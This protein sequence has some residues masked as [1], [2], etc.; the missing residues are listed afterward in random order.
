MRNMQT[1]KGSG[2]GI[3][4]LMIAASFLLLL[5]GCQGPMGPQGARTGTVSLTIGQ[6]DMSRALQ[7]DIG[8]ED[9]DDFSIVFSR[10]GTTLPP[11]DWDDDN[12]VITAQ[13]E[14]AE[15]TWNLKVEA[16][17]D[18]YVVAYFDEPVNVVAPFTGLDIY[19]RPYRESGY[20][21]FA[22][23]LTLPDAEYVEIAEGIV[24][25]FFGTVLVAYDDTLSAGDIYDGEWAGKFDDL[26]AGDYFVVVTLTTQAGVSVSISTY[27]HV[28]RNLTTTLEHEFLVADFP[29][30]AEVALARIN[31]A[32]W[33]PFTQP[34]EEGVSEEDTVA[35]ALNRVRG[36]VND[37]V[38]AA[39]VDAIA[40]V[41]WVTVP[42]LEELGT[43][44]TSY[45]FTV[46]VEGGDGSLE[47]TVINV[48][49]TFGAYGVVVTVELEDAIDEAMYLLGNTYISDDGLD[50]EISDYWAPPLA[51]EALGDA[52]D[53]AETYLG[54]TQTQV[55]EAVIA[56]NEAIDDFL[57]ARERG[58][59]DPFLTAARGLLAGV[60]EEAEELL[61]Y[62]E[63]A[64]HTV[65]TW[66]AFTTAL[67][68]AQ[69]AYAN[70]VTVPALN[71]AREALEE[72]MNGLETLLEE[73]L[74]LLAAAIANAPAIQGDYSDD[75]WEAFETALS[76][77][78][79]AYA[80]AVTVLDLD[81]ARVALAAAIGGLET[82]IQETRKLLGLALDLANPRLSDHYTVDSWSGFPGIRLAA[83]EAYANDAAT[84]EQL[85]AA[86]TAL[87]TAMGNLIPRTEYYRELLAEALG[88]AD[89]RVQ[90]TYTGDSWNAFVVIRE[91]SRDVHDDDDA[92]V[93]ALS[94]ANTN[95]RNA[96]ANVLVTA[97]DQAAVNAAV[98]TVRAALAPLASNE[99]TAAELLAAANAA[100]TGG[101][102]AAWEVDFGRTNATQADV[103]EITGTIRLRLGNAIADVVLD[104]EIPALPVPGTVVIN[105][106]GFANPLLAEGLT[107]TATGAL[108]GPGTFAITG[109]SEALGALEN[110]RWYEGTNRIGTGLM[111]DRNWM[112]PVVTVWVDVG[113]STYSRIVVLTS[114][115]N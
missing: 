69:Y 51:H 102:T 108:G 82:V 83:Q 56:L 89:L 50:V 79:Y 96:M 4:A 98:A 109:S 6:L 42:D 60:I 34:W 23:L 35:I 53:L 43:P 55:N 84:L 54:G 73:A 31:A 38:Y 75:S 40:T 8:L 25:V 72:A 49:I 85:Q 100:L 26:T 64:D 113:D 15:G 10:D 28:Y 111:L 78:Q 21:V 7:P 12:G 97:V 66:E 87:N 1:L 39:G 114:A 81:T 62:L 63:E 19:L 48:T 44:A 11:L 24:E 68:A 59:Y 36:Y 46:D 104:L 14:L 105:W 58:L 27:I 93:L 71:T 94:T 52:I 17:M 30:A 16:L 70:A 2:I 13:I 57:D 76:A 37:V 41:D 80:N 112:P 110:I 103:G 92:S 45:G 91:A 115:G 32:S 20:G 33:T 9:F 29:T 106:G 22:W 65:I 90:A 101:M 3:F 99:I 67:Y 95:L 47:S 74:R 86:L 88:L 5:P 18:G 61:D 107:I 77:A